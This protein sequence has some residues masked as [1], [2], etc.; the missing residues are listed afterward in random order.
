MTNSIGMLKYYVNNHQHAK[1]QLEIAKSFRDEV[2]FTAFN[3]GTSQKKLQYLTGLSERQI[4]SIIA[5][6]RKLDI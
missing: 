1:E 5:K 3:E 2:I 6:Q 4:K